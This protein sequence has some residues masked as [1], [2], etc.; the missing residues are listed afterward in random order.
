ML[1][2]G[3]ILLQQFVSMR[4][5]KDQQKYSSVDGSGGM[6]QKTMM[7]MMTVMFAIFSFMYSAAFSIYMIMSNVNKLVKVSMDKKEQ[8]AMRRKYNNR[9]P[10]RKIEEKNGKNSKK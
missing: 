2:I 5:Q 10:G 8:E 1:S 6:N 9:I 7:I 3:T 4:S